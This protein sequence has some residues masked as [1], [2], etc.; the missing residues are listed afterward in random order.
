MAA[1][2]SDI[3]SKVLFSNKSSTNVLSILSMASNISTH[4]MANKSA[5]T[6]CIATHLLYNKL[7]KRST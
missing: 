2:M 5:R 7:Q 3:P 1:W 4:S 6:T